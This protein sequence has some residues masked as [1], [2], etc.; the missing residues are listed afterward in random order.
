MTPKVWEFIG[1][2]ALFFS[3]FQMWDIAGWEGVSVIVGLAVAL[4][5]FV[6]SE[7]L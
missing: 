3:I 4:L 7:G 5:G 2:T 6:K 1:R